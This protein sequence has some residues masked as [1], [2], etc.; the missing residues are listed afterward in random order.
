[1]FDSSF[2]GR[3]VGR[4]LN[5]YQRAYRRSAYVVAVIYDRVLKMEGAR[6]YLFLRI[7]GLLQ[8]QCYFNGHAP[9]R[10]H[11]RVIYT[12]KISCWV[13][14]GIP[15]LLHLST[16]LFEVF[17]PLNLLISAATSAMVKTVSLRNVAILQNREVCGI[18]YDLRPY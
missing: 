17:V 2:L 10:S 15:F 16:V 18:G 12:P 11:S 9:L 8:P 7:Q 3:T 14:V 5:V 6:L 1:M 13:T 4:L